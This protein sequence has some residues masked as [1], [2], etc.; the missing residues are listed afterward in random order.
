MSAFFRRTLFVGFGAFRER[1]ESAALWS[2]IAALGCSQ[3]VW[4]QPAP[5]DSA[6]QPVVLRTSADGAWWILSRPS[7]EHTESPAWVRPTEE[8]AIAELSPELLR[9]RL[10]AAPPEFENQP[11]LVIEVPNPDG[12]FTEFSVVRSPVMHPDLQARYPEIQTYAGRSV[13]ASGE[14][15]RISVTP[16][17]FSAQVLGPD[18]AWYVDRFSRFDDAVYS[19]YRRPDIRTDDEW[20]CAFVSTDPA[21]AARHDRSPARPSGDELR[22]FR[23]AIACTGE[24]TAF[25]G[26]TVP[27]ALA[28]VVTA[29]NRVN[30]IYEREL[31][32]RMQ[33][34]PNN[35]QIIYTNAGSDPYS[36]T[37]AGAMLGQNQ[38]TLDAVIGFAN[39]D[40]GH[41]FSTGGGG[42]AFLGA[43]CTS[44]KAGGVT[45]LPSPIGDPFYV[46]YVA[47]EMGHQ[48]GANHTF[49]GLDGSCSGGNR[50]GSTAYEP[51]GASTIMGYA[52][53]CGTDDLQLNSDPYFHSVSYDEINSLVS[54][55]PC[56]ALTP[57]GNTIPTISAGPS[58]TIP[59]GTPFELTASGSDADPGNVLTYRWEQRDLGPARPLELTDNGSSPL[60]RS[61]EGTASPT[62]VFPRLASVLADADT[63]GEHLPGTNRTMNFRVTIKDNAIGGGG[64]AFADTVVQSTTDAGPFRVTSHND[65]GSYEGA[66]EVTWDV[67]RTDSGAVSTPLVDIYLSTDGGQT[68]PYQ[69]A[70]GTPNDGG[71]FVAIPVAGASA[72]IKVKGSGNAFFAVNNSDIAVQPAGLAI[73]LHDGGPTHLAPTTP[74]TLRVEI[75]AG[76]STLVPG[77][78]A[79]RYRVSGSSYQTVPLIPLGGPDFEA[80][81]PPV[82]CG[83]VFEYYISAESA[84]GATVLSP[85]N[86][87]AIPSRVE[88]GTPT[89]TL[90]DNAQTNI[91]WAVSGSAT[92]GQWSRGVPIGFG[93][94]DPPTDASGSGAAWVTDNSGANSGNSDVDG[95]QTA[96]TS[97]TLDLSDGGE[98]EYRYWFND[99]SLGPINGDRFGVEVSTDD[100]ASWT[101]VR[102]FTE[103]DHI[104]RRD[105][106]RV[107]DEVPASPTVR[108]RFSVDDLGAQ[109]IV[110]GGM[111][112]LVVRVLDCTDLACSPA[113]LNKDGVLDNGDIVLLVAAFLG[114]DLA[115]D[116]NGDGILDN[117][118]IIAF[119]STFLAGC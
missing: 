44:S 106:I 4:G 78:A 99:I 73:L 12:E 69:L 52:G 91:G 62:R 2:V 115:V 14:S 89:V 63:D 49:N 79:M 40:I 66:L 32:V 50:N 88:V 95:G 111:D 110:E 11:P 105:V 29:M 68:F 45:G 30:G 86:G 55:A 70:A 35:D 71:E 64:L 104:W 23:V 33:L 53:I 10:A 19:S 72:R 56:V 90:S 8:A 24:Y 103:P 67:A 116:I 112:N 92:D 109:N 117:G 25:H 107:G 38:S 9:N 118:D 57:T 31:A 84:S 101:S 85:P 80:T 83:D 87:Q 108:I 77:S 13:R 46:D 65:S 21:D 18:G 43:V 17:G 27:D 41:V 61:F 96:L 7:S 16:T 114:G 37:N 39:Y 48:F 102:A 76:T 5:R 81:L 59:I 97:P 98:I 51:G 74:T 26:G 28:A 36:N 100:G 93:R 34:V 42:V 94:A 54:N 119:I 58:Y 82:S 6:G 3:I 15:I 1:R 113:D 22:T 75:L 60:F 47:H 20:T